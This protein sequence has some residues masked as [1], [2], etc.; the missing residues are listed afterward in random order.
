[1]KKK[2]RSVDRLLAGRLI[3]ERR[4]ARPKETSTG[5]RFLMPA[6]L[7]WPANRS[8]RTAL[9]F[10]DSSRLLVFKTKR[11][12]ENQVRDDR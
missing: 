10:H 4:D 6:F 7:C 12:D 8:Q 2:E 1:M 11:E 9:S 3:K 5:D